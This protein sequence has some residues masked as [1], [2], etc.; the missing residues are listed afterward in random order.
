MLKV[1][2]VFRFEPPDE[3]PESQEGS[4]LIY[5]GPNEAYLIVSS[6]MVEASPGMPVIDPDG[7]S[8]LFSS[9]MKSIAGLAADPE[10]REVTALH[11][12]TDFGSLETW[13]QSY[14]TVDN[15]VAFSQAIVVAA[16]GV[17][18]ASLESPPWREHASVFRDFLKTVEA[19]A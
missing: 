11:K 19:L 3:W 15:A 4:R 7:L 13:V 17:L 18:L 9:A 2:R 8:Q 6:A 12:S 10:F 1:G 14:I 5:R 16:S